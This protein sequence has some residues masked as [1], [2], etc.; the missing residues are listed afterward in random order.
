M[1]RITR[2]EN[3]ELAAILTQQY[4][5]ISRG[6]A[7]ASGMT[8]NALRHRLREGGPWQRLLPGVFLAVTGTPTGEQRHVAAL[9][10]A[11]PSSVLTGAAALSLCGVR[12]PHTSLIDV[13]VPAARRRMSTGFVRVHLTTRLPEQPLTAGPLRYAPLVR[14]VADTAR[15]LTSLSDVRALVAAVVQRG[16]C[17]PGQLAAEL[18]N[19]PSQ[20][21]ALLRMAIGDVR[22]GIRSSPEADLKDLLSHAKLPVPQ[23]NPR[24]YIDDDFIASPDAW[25][26]HAGV[27]AEVDS[28]EYHLSPADHE[29]TLAR[30]ARMRAHGINVLH[31]TP[32]QIRTQPAQVI[33][34]LKAALA[35]AG[36]RPPLPVRARPAHQRPER[37]EAPVSRR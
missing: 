3:T 8:A 26:L 20:G 21:S 11:G 12:A 7:L 4:Q 36:S 28:G 10:Y 24:L 37:P 35:N 9:L 23:F 14:A 1:T 19:G 33:A 5:V 2:P 15:G 27:A 30:D 31:F 32:R 13:L 25:W 34:I 17:T 29:R 18:E 16:K 22:E 6:Q